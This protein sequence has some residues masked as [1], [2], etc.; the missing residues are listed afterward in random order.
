MSKKYNIFRSFGFAFAGIK[1]ALAHNINLRIHFVIAFFVVVG[2]IA[3]HLNKFEAILA[4]TMI[5]LVISTEMMNTVVEELV[6]LV[7]KEYR[8]EARIA[9]DVAAGMVLVISAGAAIVGFLIFYPHIAQ[10][11]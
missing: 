5:V 1:S 2:S 11:F 8:E 7:T 3:L 6:N 4:T 10:L 9:K